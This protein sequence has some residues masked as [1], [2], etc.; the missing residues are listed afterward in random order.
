MVGTA[1]NG[2][3]RDLAVDPVEQWA[4]IWDGQLLPIRFGKKA[5]ASDHLYG[6]QT[7]IVV[8]KVAA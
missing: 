5:E 2:V 6:L 7:G 8:R 1:I 3:V 4:V